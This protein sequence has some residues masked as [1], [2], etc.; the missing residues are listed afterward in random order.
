[1]CGRPVTVLFLCTGN[2]A[3]SIMA[4]AILNSIGCGGFVA[5]SAGSRPSAHVNPAAIA[6]LASCGHA[7]NGLRSKSWDEFAPAGAPTFDFVIT[8]C[9]R[10]AGESCPVWTGSPL[11][12][13]WGIAD[14]AAARGGDDAIRKAFDDAYSQLERR[15][16]ALV[17]LPLESMDV[18]AIRSA[19]TEIAVAVDQS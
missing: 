8:V 9:D 7:T 18:E 6:K 1:M 12:A 16:G 10:A 17:R 19:L 14:P 5:F 13:H 15:I 3:R 2:S 4:E 11:A